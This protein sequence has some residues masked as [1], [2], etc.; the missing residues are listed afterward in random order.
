MLLKF[1]DNGVRKWTFRLLRA[2]LAIG[3]SRV[4]LCV[5]DPLVRD[6]A[7]AVAAI[8]I[9]ASFTLWRVIW[10]TMSYPSLAIHV[11]MNGA[12]GPKNVLEHLICFLTRH[13]KWEEI[14]GDL[15][16]ERLWVAHRLGKTSGNVWYISNALGDIVVAAW[17]F[18]QTL[19][20]EWEERLNHVRL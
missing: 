4:A 16:E 9:V 20:L 15:R 8:A 18:P 3:S 19:C 11:R 12:S 17:L 14:L 6:V 13:S 1:V 10:R 7:L 5:G 2:V